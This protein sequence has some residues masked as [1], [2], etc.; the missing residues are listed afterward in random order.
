MFKKHD[1]NNW[2]DGIMEF[3]MNEKQSLRKSET[4]AKSYS[5]APFI[6]QSTNPVF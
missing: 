6:H 1:N 4:F 2:S 5:N 3:L